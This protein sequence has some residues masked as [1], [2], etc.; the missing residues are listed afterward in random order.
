MVPYEAPKSVSHEETFERDLDAD[1]DILRELL[2]LSGRVAAR[3]REDGYRARTVVLKARL[4]NFHDAHP[5][6]D[7]PR[8]DGHRRGSVP[9]RGGALRRAPRAAPADP[10]A[11]RAGD[12]AGPGRGRAAR[13]AP[14]GA[15]GR[16]RA[17]DRSDRAAVRSRRGAS[18]LAD[19]ARSQELSRAS[20]LKVSVAPLDSYNRSDDLSPGQVG[21][22]MPLSEHEQRILEEIE[23][24]LARGGSA[25]GRAGRQDRP[26]HPSVPSHP[27]GRA[28]VLRRPAAD[29]AVRRRRRGSPRSAS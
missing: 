24:G 20:A 2:D 21:K 12:R 23:K 27:D 10:P 25:P 22:R 13:D 19:R 18:G 8:R 5:V 4:A 11:R 3:L 15:L 29:P 16:R 28:R 1:E 26:L 9:D 6:P 14:R 17:R 7:A